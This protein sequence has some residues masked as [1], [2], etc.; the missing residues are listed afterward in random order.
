MVIGYN[1]G[2]VFS[3]HTPRVITTRINPGLA[4]PSSSQVHPSVILV[5]QIIEQGCRT[6]GLG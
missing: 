2:V 5:L 3:L 6:A 4:F 1:L